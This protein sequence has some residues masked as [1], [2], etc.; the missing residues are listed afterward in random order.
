MFRMCKQ[1]DPTTC[2]GGL[3]TH[4][5]YVW[6]TTKAQQNFILAAEKESRLKCVIVQYIFYCVQFI[7]VVEFNVCWRKNE[8]NMKKNGKMEFCVFAQQKQLNFDEKV[9]IGK[10]QHVEHH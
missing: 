2:S 9:L 8:L 5:Q 4:T 6:N 7:L 10:G 3:K 1:S